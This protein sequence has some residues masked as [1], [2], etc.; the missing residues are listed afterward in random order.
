MGWLVWWI[1][2]A[3]SRKMIDEIFRTQVVGEHHE[4]L[5]SCCRGYSWWCAAIRDKRTGQVW[6]GISKYH[7][8]P[9]NGEF[10]YKWMDET[11]GP[12]FT[13]YPKSYF[14]MLSPTD[15]EYAKQWRERQQEEYDRR[16]KR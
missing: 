8:N 5:K 2:K 13:N 6:A 12:Y 14:K 7:Y 10:G 15:S 16:A 4:V 1:G 3:G 9:K 11:Y